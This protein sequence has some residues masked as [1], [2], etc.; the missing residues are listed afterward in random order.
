[1]EGVLDRLDGIIG[2]SGV[3]THI[4][5][6]VAQI[7]LA[8]KKKLV[9]LPGGK[10]NATMHMIFSGNPGTGKTTVAR[11]VA[12]VRRRLRRNP[13]P[14]HLPDSYCNASAI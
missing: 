7:Q 13:P 14:P 10:V 11:I 4:R 2:L 3:K 8:N 5:S 6:L 1:M 9:G 12:E